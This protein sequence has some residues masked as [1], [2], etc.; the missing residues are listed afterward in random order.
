MFSNFVFADSFL[1]KNI[2]KKI[3]IDTYVIVINI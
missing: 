1:I 2:I 3:P